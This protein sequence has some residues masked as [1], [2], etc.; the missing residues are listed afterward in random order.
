VIVT[1]AAASHRDSDRRARRPPPPIVIVAGRDDVKIRRR[2]EEPDDALSDEEVV[3]GDGEPDR[4]RNDDNRGP[5][6][7]PTV[8]P[9]YVTGCPLPGCCP[10]RWVAANQPLWNPDVPGYVPEDARF[11]SGKVPT[12]VE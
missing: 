6:V 5:R 11:D 2:G 4:H 10:G 9:C 8:S 7:V 12:Y 1:T 3:F